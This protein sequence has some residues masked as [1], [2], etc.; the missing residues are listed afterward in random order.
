MWFLRRCFHANFVNSKFLTCW[1]AGIQPV[2]LK[3][4][5]DCSGWKI[6]KVSVDFNLLIFVCLQEAALRTFHISDDPRN[7]SLTEITDLGNQL[8]SCSKLVWLICLQ[9][10]V[11][12]AVDL[13][14][15]YWIRWHI[16]LELFQ[17]TVLSN[18]IIYMPHF[19]L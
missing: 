11:Q 4:D 19:T 12:A 6:R 5:A 14:W 2:L 8:L 10:W 15:W 16:R 18:I 13:V 7:F 3:C 17:I 9:C 1:L